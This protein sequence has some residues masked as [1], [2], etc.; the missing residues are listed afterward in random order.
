[1]PF[2]H[3][4]AALGELAQARTEP[5]GLLRITAPYDCGTSV[6]VPVVTAFTSLTRNARWN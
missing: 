5:K 2:G 6:V 4:Y 3:W 1:M